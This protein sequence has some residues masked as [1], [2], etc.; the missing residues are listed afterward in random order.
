MAN[1]IIN[2]YSSFTNVLSKF[3]FSITPETGL[4][5]I[6]QVGDHTL[7]INLLFTTPS[8]VTSDPILAYST[9]FDMGRCFVPMCEA[10]SGNVCGLINVNGNTIYLASNQW[11]PS[12]RVV[13]HTVVNFLN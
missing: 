6:T 5:S 11:Q 13:V 4:T 7:Y 9:S 3:T 8:T 2:N 1:S 12:K 10:Y